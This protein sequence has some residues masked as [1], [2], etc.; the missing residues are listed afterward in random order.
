MV[1]AT[2]TAGTA[3]YGSAAAYACHQS[4]GRG[5]QLE[6]GTLT[7][8]LFLVLVLLLLLQMLPENRV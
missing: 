1:S 5:V 8:G 4:G 2:A 3:T 7:L 6:E